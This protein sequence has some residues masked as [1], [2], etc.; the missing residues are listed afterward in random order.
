M[1]KEFELPSGALLKIQLAPFADSKALYQA[2]LEEMKDIQ[3]NSSDEL[4]NLFKDAA[5]AGFSSKKIEAALEVCFK[6]CLYNDLKI[7]RNT[8]EP[9]EARQDFVHVCIY[10]AQENIMPF[11]KSLSAQFQQLSATRK[12]AQA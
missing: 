4:F 9:E 7:D 8:F 6:R 10:V 3:L 5:C 2:V 12:S 11:L 1:S